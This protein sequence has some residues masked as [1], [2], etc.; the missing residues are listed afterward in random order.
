MANPRMSESSIRIK[1]RGAEIAEFYGHEVSQFWLTIRLNRHSN[2]VS[3]NS[4]FSPSA[5]SAP[6]RFILLHLFLPN[7]SMRHRIRN[8]VDR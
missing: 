4:S 3:L 1:R 8:D 2:L 7:A 5:S 6:L